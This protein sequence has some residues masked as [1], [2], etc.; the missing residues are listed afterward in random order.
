LRS[1]KDVSIFEKINLAVVAQ[2]YWSDNSVSVT[3]SFDP[4]SEGKYIKTVL[5]MHEGQLKTVSF[6]P[7]SNAT[8]PQMPYTE[9]EK[10]EYEEWAYSLF[11]VD[12]SPIYDGMGW[13]AE[14]ERFCTT[15]A[16]LIE[17]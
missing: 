16:C 17:A 9:V 1:E 8:Y 5:D 3:V 7:M 14:G 2:R 13:D 12:L 4:D 6:L 11:P 15:D 10:S